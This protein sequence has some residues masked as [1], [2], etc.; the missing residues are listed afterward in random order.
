MRGLIR[1]W[2][3]YRD[4]NPL[5]ALQTS[6]SD[7]SHTPSYTRRGRNQVWYANEV[8]RVLCPLSGALQSYG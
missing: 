3:V 2:E 5:L 1:R 7:L 6:P 4:L 8:A